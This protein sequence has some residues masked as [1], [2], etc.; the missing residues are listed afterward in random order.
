M[1]MP[2]IGECHLSFDVHP[3]EQPVGRRTADVET[4][5]R[6]GDVPGLPLEHVCHQ[7]SLRRSPILCLHRSLPLLFRVLRLAES[8][9]RLAVSV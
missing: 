7:L 9:A 6:S 4:G 5:C 2:P 1:P 3:L 8:V